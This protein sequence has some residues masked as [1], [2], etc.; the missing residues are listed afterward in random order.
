MTS[1]PGSNKKRNPYYQGPVS[2][3]FDGQ[4]FF[5]PGGVEPG[6]AFDLLRWQFGGGRVRWP[7][8]VISAFPPARPDRHVFGEQMRVTMVGH[9]SMLVQIAGL[10][11]LTDPVWSERVS[12]F[13]SVGPKRVVPPGI[14][15]EDLPHIDLVLVTHNHYDHLD[16]VTLARLH[17]AHRPKI[18]TPLGNDTIIRRIVPDADIT[19]VDWGD[20]IAV[21]A[22]VTIDV[23]P[24]HHWSARGM[25]DQR[26]ALW[27]AFVLATPAGKIYHIGDT[28]FHDGINYEAAARKHGG[29]RLAI[30]PFGAYEPRW[31]MKGQHQNPE[32][33]VKGMKLCNAAYVAGHHFATFQLTDEGIDAPVQAL[34]AALKAEGMEPDRFRPLRAGE[35]FDVP[36]A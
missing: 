27:A 31:F 23:E 6:S 11:I 13:R 34:D 2:D 5:N 18:V 25:G 7:N 32:E 21:K 12:P 20:R 9:A 33:A 4:R 17:Q 15:F 30:L 22:D 3:H 19:V 29:F 10:N 8:P 36:V 28:G 1:S 24:C 26:M 16:L 14:R 35:V